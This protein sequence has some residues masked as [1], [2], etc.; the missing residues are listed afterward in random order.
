MKRKSEF[1]VPTSKAAL[2]P[3]PPVAPPPAKLTPP[4][5][6]PE[7]RAAELKAKLKPTP[8]R[9]RAP[10][11]EGTC[12]DCG[13]TFSAGAD[14]KCR[15]CGA[16]R[17]EE[18]EPHDS[19]LFEAE[20]AE[21]DPDVE[22]A[23]AALDIVVEGEGT[24]IPPIATFDEL[25]VLPDYVSRALVDM[26]CNQP[27]PVQAQA[28]PIIMAGH[29]LIGVARTGSGK[30]LA[31]L[32]PGIVH[33]EQQE[34][35]DPDVA[36]PIALVLAPTRELAQQIANCA[37]Q[38]LMNSCEGNHTRGLWAQEVYGGKQRQ[39][40]LERA[41]GCAIVVATPGRLSDFVESEELFLDRVTYFVLDEADR[42]LD[43]GFQGDVQKFSGF[44]PPDRQMLFFSATWPTEVEDLAT[45]LCHNSRQPA[46]IK[47]AQQEG[48]AISTRSDIVQT[49]VVFDQETAEERDQ[50]KQKLLYSHVRETMQDP[51][52]KIL[53][54]VSSKALADELATALQD[55]GFTTESMHGGRQ[56][57]SRDNA[58]W[59]FKEGEVRL[60]VATDVMGRGI[61]IPTISHVVIFDMGDIEDYVHRIGRTARGLSGLQGHA[62][63][64]FEYSYKWPE[65]AGELVKVLAEGGQEVPSELQHIADQVESGEREE[66]DRARQS[67]K[68]KKK[69]WATDDNWSN[70]DWQSSSKDKG[71][72]TKSSWDKGWR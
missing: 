57:H 54:F 67:S 28:L 60:L 35:L 66:F 29:D 37:G 50:E 20:A 47:V 10:A 40:Q 34:P 49:V 1:L 46:K 53:V 21:P 38:L 44:I 18:P 16:R 27:L 68:W 30:T 24:D 4:W 42:M 61:D 43:M 8:T 15:K 39:A 26:Q 45:S 33:I 71:W 6:K 70:S 59:K 22:S 17:P 58:L 14:R 9:A 13:W 65:I 3:K 56:Q 11:P 72:E 52:S 62:L 51:D 64:L 7:Q 2:R 5:A 36:S 12:A 31:F 69:K 19:E 63:T 48:G 55:E 25:G 32:L 23:R 41:R